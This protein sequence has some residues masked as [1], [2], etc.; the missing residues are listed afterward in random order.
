MIASVCLVALLAAMMLVVAR[1]V[2]SAFYLSA[3]SRSLELARASADNTALLA[4][5]AT[6]LEAARRQ[7]PGNA[8]VL[9]RLA[10]VYALQGRPDEAIAVLEQAR[11]AQ[12][13]SLLVSVA[14]AELYARTGR[15][16]EST[17]IYSA[18]G[19]SPAAMIGYADQFFTQGRYAEA[20]GWYEQGAATLLQLPDDAAFR[21]L[22]ALAHLSAEQVPVARDLPGVLKLGPG[23]VTVQGAHL[24]MLQA[25]S[26][27]GIPYG[28]NI[29][30]AF[31]RTGNPSAAP[32]GLLWVKSSAGLVALAEQPG[33]YALRIIVRHRGDPPADLVLTLND[34]PLHTVQV[35]PPQGEWQSVEQQLTLRRGLH[36]IGIQFT[37]PLFIEGGEDRKLE[38]ASVSLRKLP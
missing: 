27:L 18:L 12:P 3:G 16:E 38:I 9:R 31:Q 19:R 35:D 2:S 22:V 11:I 36:L 13:K 23:E 24:H 6:S 30:L 34:A 1:P 5:A 29:D 26:G 37:N 20:A 17:T 8:L 14:L 33:A 21:R 15:I 25:I 28:T 7:D 32:S 10:D 4:Q